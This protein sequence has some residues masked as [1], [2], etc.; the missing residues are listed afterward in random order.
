MSL[1]ET[2]ILRS[3]CSPPTF[4]QAAIFLLFLPHAHS[5]DFYMGAETDFYRQ[6]VHPTFFPIVSGGVTSRGDTH[7]IDAEI[8]FSPTHPKAYTFSSKNLYWGEKDSS[9]DSPLRLTFGR[10]LIGWSSIDE[11]WQLGTIEPLDSWDRLRSSE[12]GLTGIFAYTETKNM[13]FRFFASYLALPEMGPNAVIQNG[14][15]A[16]EHPQAISTVPQTITI[17]NQA[18]AL[19]YDLQIPSISKIIFRPSIMFMTETKPEFSFY[20]K[21]VYGYLPLNYYPIALQANYSITQDKVLVTLYPRLLYHHVY[22][23][24]AGYKIN[25]H[26]SIGMN[27]MVDQI[28]DDSVPSSYD[29]TPLS[30]TVTYSPYFKFRIPRWKFLA[31]QLW[32]HGGIENSIGPDQVNL[33]SRIL[34]RNASQLSAAFEL[35]PESPYRPMLQMKEIHEYSI[36]ADW[37][38]ADFSFTPRERLTLFVGGDLITAEKGVSSDKGGEFLADMKT[39]DRIRVGVHYVF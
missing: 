2:P 36:L 25:D 24:E 19:S 16:S 20:G 23:G 4:L 35:D 27:V 38:S 33:S 5:A 32:S 21:L 7:D 14:Q 10:R 11:M 17:L 18:S 29:M 1:Q 31:S 12:Q 6:I 3:I 26:T 8:K 37:V 28:I 9:T 30:T 34:Y 39:L 15:F 13:S 22:N